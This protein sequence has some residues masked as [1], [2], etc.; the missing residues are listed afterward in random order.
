[1]DRTGIF[2]SLVKELAQKGVEAALAC[3]LYTCT[4][5]HTLYPNVHKHTACT[6]IKESD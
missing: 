5:M 2:F 3:T 1:M 4:H 6:G